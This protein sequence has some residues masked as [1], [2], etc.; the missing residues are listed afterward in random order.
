MYDS[1]PI[2]RHNGTVDTGASTSA[3][4]ESPASQ[5]PLLPP[6]DSP[7][8]VASGQ[9]NVSAIARFDPRGLA[10]DC[11]ILQIAAPRCGR[12]AL[13]PFCADIVEQRCAGSVRL[14]L[15][16]PELTPC[17]SA[18]DCRLCGEPT[19]RHAVLC[20]H[21]GLIS[22]A[23]CQEFAPA[24]ESRAQLLLS[25]FPTLLSRPQSGESSFSLA[26]YNPFGRTRRSRQSSHRSSADLSASESLSKTPMRPLSGVLHASRT[27][28]SPPVTLS[29]VSTPLARR[30]MSPSPARGD[31]NRQ[32]GVHRAHAIRAGSSSPSADIASS[33]R[34]QLVR[35]PRISFDEPQSPTRSRNRPLPGVSLAVGAEAQPLS[36]DGRRRPG[37]ARSASQPNAHWSMPQR[38]SEC[39]PM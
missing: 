32:Q 28:I 34:P 8:G 23:R 4:C 33:G 11:H 26:D 12:N 39:R 38:R 31:L 22:H 6:R 5:P 13:A 7:L 30:S 20:K 21:C 36:A 35:N 10:S 37:H 25:R 14:Q 29:R 24:C 3:E 17:R 16:V 15:V 2:R 1:L 9:Q 27:R 18:V 19:K